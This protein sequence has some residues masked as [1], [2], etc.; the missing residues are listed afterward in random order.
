VIDGEVLDDG[1]Q[2]GIM[3]DVVVGDED[4]VDRSMQV[5]AASEKLVEIRDQ[6]R[7]RSWSVRLVCRL[8]P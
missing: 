6:A 1:P 3:I 4:C 2:A 5:S 7:P 8:R